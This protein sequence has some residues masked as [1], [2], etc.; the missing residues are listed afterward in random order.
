MGFATDTLLQS[1]MMKLLCHRN[2]TI[3]FEFQASDWKLNTSEIPFLFVKCFEI[4][5]KHQLKV[6]AHFSF[7]VCPYLSMSDLFAPILPFIPLFAFFR[8][9]FFHFTVYPSFC[10]SCCLTTLTS[11]CPLGNFF[12]RTIYRQ[13]FASRYIYYPIDSRRID[14]IAKSLRLYAD[15]VAKV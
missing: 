15:S 14:F 13:F 10:L 9:F 3:K 11:H 7:P 8:W 12:S 1:H 4:K 2:T 5:L 6:V